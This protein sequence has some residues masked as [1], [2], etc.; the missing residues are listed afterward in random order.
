[1]ASQNGASLTSTNILDNRFQVNFCCNIDFHVNSTNV[2]KHLE[3]QKM[4][5]NSVRRR[6][7]VSRT[8]KLTYYRRVVIT[9]PNYGFVGQK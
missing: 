8:M 5:A 6:L 2:S 9:M 1:M 4:I 3:C 7:R